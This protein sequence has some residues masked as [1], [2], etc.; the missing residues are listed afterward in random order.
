MIDV[1]LTGFDLCVCRYG[2]ST[3]CRRPFG[4]VFG[5]HQRAI[6]ALMDAIGLKE[7]AAGVEASVSEGESRNA[8]RRSDS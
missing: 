2:R 3:G 7:I 4:G 1:T 8:C 5:V 6:Y